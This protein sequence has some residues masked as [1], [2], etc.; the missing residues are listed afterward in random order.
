MTDGR[1]DDIEAL[2]QAVAARVDLEDT[3]LG[4]DDEKTDSGLT[5]RYVRHCLRANEVGDGLLYI[6]LMQGRFVYN[7][8]AGEWLSWVGHYWQRD[9]R[10]LSG[11]AVEEVVMEYI[12]AAAGLEEI[13]KDAESKSETDLARKL[14]DLQ[15]SYH[16]RAKKLRSINGIASCLRAARMGQFGLTIDGDEFDQRPWLLAC[17]NGVIDLRNGLLRNGR[18]DD[19]LT[20][21]CPTE[22]QGLD[23][24][25]APIEAV[26]LSVFNDRQD[27][28]DYTRKV[29]GYAITGHSKIHDFFAWNGIGRNGKSMLIEGISDT[30]GELAQPIPAE[31]LLE[32]PGARGA[33]AAS[34]DIM[35]LRGLRIAYASETDEGRKFS[36]SR[37]K[38]LTGGDK[39]T[40]RWPHDKR[41]ITFLPTHTLFL[42]TNHKPRAGADDFAFWERCRLFHFELS[43]IKDREPNPDKNE[44]RADPDLPEQFKQ[45]AS[46]HLSWLVNGCLEWQRDGH[47]APPPYVREAT[48]EYRREEDLIQ[49]WIDECVDTDEDQEETKAST[50]YGNFEEWYKSSVGKKPPSAKWFG[51]QLMRRYERVKR[52]SGYFYIGLRLI[53]LEF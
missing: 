42:L 29:L 18:P 22:Y 6:A 10:D 40:G 43:Y 44:R 35:S 36:S 48:A 17:P 27:V 46:L 24:D 47:L 53:G 28:V 2:Q 9:T 1:L 11:S 8:S 15:S 7:A 19:Y 20:M 16:K 23:V 49:D 32:Q 52:S 34:P 51:K 3:A 12:N 30:L 13:I 31:M 33:A 37:V 21:A 41:P 50:L 45:M 5:K 39:L 25:T 14:R 4:G 38:W 26:Y